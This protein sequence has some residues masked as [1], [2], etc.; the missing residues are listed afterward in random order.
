MR[1]QPVSVPGQRLVRQFSKCGALLLA[2]AMLGGCTPE[3]D[4]E[5]VVV[6]DAR[7]IPSQYKQINRSFKTDRL[8]FAGPAARMP[9]PAKRSSLPRGVG[10]YASLDSFFQA[11]G[12]LKSGRRTEP[13]TVLHLGDS[14]IAADRFSGDLRAHFQ[15]RFGDAGRGMMMPGYPFPYYQA[16]GISFAKKGKWSAANSFKGDSGPYGLSGV[17]L[18]ARAKSASLSLKI[19]EG[20]AEWAEVTFVRQPSGGDATV[21]FG[22]ARRTISTKGVTGTVTTARL[23]VKGSKLSVT[24]RDNKPVSVLSWAV[25]QNRPGLRYVNFGIPGATAD[26]PRRWSPEIVA[27]GLKRLKPDLIILGYGTNEGFNDALEMP[28]YERRVSELVTRLKNDAP[29]SSFLIMGP[30]DS[31][32]LPRFARKGGDTAAAGCTSLSNAEIRNYAHLKSTSSAKLAQWHAPPSLSRVRTSLQSVARQSDA[33]FWDWSKVMGG[34][35]G[36]HRWA[37]ANP[38]L[39]ARDRVH[40]RSAGAKRSAQVLFEEIMA[41]FEAHVRLASR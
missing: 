16:R 36:I 10:K 20:A 28:A 24:P 6:R 33:Y 27:D 38:P 13:V 5:K 9:L 29:Q 11:L 2:F 37:L 15:R 31:A 12:D 22:G 7:D 39:A 18:T 3:S 32:R 19:R 41:G 4:R 14:H 34:P 1:C 17:R 30:P 21:I 35:C 40:L 25:G 23:D 26:T 8:E